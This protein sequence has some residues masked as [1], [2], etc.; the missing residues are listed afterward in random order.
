MLVMKY[1][2]QIFGTDNPMMGSLREGGPDRLTAQEFQGTAAGAV[3]RLERV[4]KVIGL[5]AMQ[6]LGYMFAYHTQQLMSEEVWVNSAGRWPEDIMAELNPQRGRVKIS[7]Y[8]LLIDY[9]LMVRDGSIPG[10]NFSNTWV[11]MFKI[12]MENPMLT[13]RFDIMR[14][15]KHI[16]RNTGAKNVEEFE[17]KGQ[18]VP[19]VNAQVLPDEQ[20]AQQA[21]AGNLVPM[22]T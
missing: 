3:S 11:Q 7:P 6:D 21:Q 15:F 19:A 22:G 17:I 10:G 12:I 2:Q 18:Q 5:Q 20:V 13:Q 8:D 1:M 9:D 16:A 4:A 14:I